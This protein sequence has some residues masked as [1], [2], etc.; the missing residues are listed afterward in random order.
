MSSDNLSY[1]NRRNVLFSATA[2]AAFPCAASA[3]DYT[4]LTWE[5]LLPQGLNAQVATP[6][7]VLPH[8]QANLLSQQPVSTGIR[9]ELNDRAVRLPGYI[10]PLEFDSAKVTSFI[11]VPYVGACIHVPPPPANQIVLVDTDE[12]YEA[13]GLFEAVYVSGVIN[14]ATANTA[15]ADVGYHIRANKIVPYE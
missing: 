3:R 6:R 8:S 10:I 1:V 13:Q 15:L 2:F 9:T 5:D 11:L 12:P 7:G 14:G 4:D